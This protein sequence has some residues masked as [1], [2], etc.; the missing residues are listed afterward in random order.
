MSNCIHEPAS[1]IVQ[2]IQLFQLR[3]YDI[4]EFRYHLP[5]NFCNMRQRNAR[6][7][8]HPL[9]TAVSDAKTAVARSYCGATNPL[10]LGYVLP[11]AGFPPADSLRLLQLCS[12]DDGSWTEE[13]NDFAKIVVRK[14]DEHTDAVRRLADNWDQV[15]SVTCEWLKDDFDPMDYP[16]AKWLSGCIDCTLVRYGQPVRNPA[17][18]S[19]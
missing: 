1:P 18:L 10:P 19:A 4:V 16:S 8:K 2:A 7:R 12:V 9:L 17:L 6:Y 13:V 11:D 3:L 15:L 14:I 5:I